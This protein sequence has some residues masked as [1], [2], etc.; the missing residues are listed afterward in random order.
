MRRM[1]FSHILLDYGNLK[2]YI[3]RSGKEA[4]TKKR[5]KYKR[6]WAALNNMTGRLKFKQ[7]RRRRI[8]SLS[9]AS[10]NLLLQQQ[11]LTRMPYELVNKSVEFESKLPKISK[12]ISGVDMSRLRRGAYLRFDNRL[13]QRLRLKQRHKRYLYR[14]RTLSFREK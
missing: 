12:E 6:S 3:F 4:K 2:D 7:I 10:Q 1:R 14:G 8:K 11:N 13:R 9:G 5:L